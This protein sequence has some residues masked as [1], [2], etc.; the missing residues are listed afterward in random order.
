MSRRRASL[1]IH[2]AVAHK[3]DPQVVRIMVRRGTSGRAHEA[4][5]MGTAQWR[6]LKASPGDRWTSALATRAQRIRDEA[7]ARAAALRAVA[8]RPVTPLELRA[9]LERKGHAPAVA[10][11][12]VRELASEGW[13]DG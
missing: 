5:R 1:T 8:R 6:S 12:I 11:R 2:S 3:G 7:G 4:A 10:S 13:L 9:Q